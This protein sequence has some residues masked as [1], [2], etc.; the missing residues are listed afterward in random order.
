MSGST[1]SI[2]Y[3]QVDSSRQSF[4]DI[5][6]GRNG[7]FEAGLKRLL[8]RLR[9]MHDQNFA[10]GGEKTGKWAPVSWWVAI[11]RKN[12]GKTITQATKLGSVASVKAQIAQAFNDIRARA[13][14]LRPLN[15]TGNLRRS[16]TGEGSAASIAEVR[17]VSLLFG[18]RVIDAEKH[19]YGGTS[20]FSF[21]ADVVARLESTIG[22]RRAT[23]S[24][25]KS[26]SKKKGTWNPL[27]FLLLNYFKKK[28]GSQHKIPQRRFV[29]ESADFNES[30]VK[31]FESI[32]KSSIPNGK[33]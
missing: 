30:D 15:D 3:K 27:F 14:T 23:P 21:S 4:L 2:K 7:G 8:L 16:L 10:T 9:K 19:Q 6:T 22:S 24:G 29:F 13:A 5:V 33:V 12:A 1:F 11:L 17:P 28:D 31:D 25:R 26:K 32:M 20:Q 18:T